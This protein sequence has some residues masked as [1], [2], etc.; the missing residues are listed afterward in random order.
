M[1]HTPE[2]AL[3]VAQ[4]RASKDP[5]TESDRASKVVARLQLGN[6]TQQSV[7]SVIALAVDGFE[8]SDCGH[9][10]DP[11]VFMLRDPEGDHH[12]AVACPHCDA[13]N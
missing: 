12:L 4:E 3:A 13:S 2:T 9:P 11:F 8:C 6:E 1:W 7:A 5:F 10:S